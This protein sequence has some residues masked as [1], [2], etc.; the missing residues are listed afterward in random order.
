MERKDI[1]ILWPKPTIRKVPTPFPKESGIPNPLAT[2]REN[3]KRK[4]AVWVE[5]QGIDSKACTRNRTNG[6]V[7]LSP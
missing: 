1:L 7:Y 6:L 4:V 2:L 3:K 5:Q